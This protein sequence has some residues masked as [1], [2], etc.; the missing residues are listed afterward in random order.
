MGT[1]SVAGPLT[2]SLH[3]LWVSGL[4]PPCNGGP[5]RI[6]GDPKT[7]Q[8]SKGSDSDLAGWQP[9]ET[10]SQLPQGKGTLELAWVVS[11]HKRE[12]AQGP[13]CAKAITKNHARKIAARLYV[14]VAESRCPMSSWYDDVSPLHGAK[15]NAPAPLSAS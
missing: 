5:V 8:A 15:S 12:G 11:L 9:K 6:V 7:D 13:Q 3:G 10:A 14:G 2:T 1:P 4:L